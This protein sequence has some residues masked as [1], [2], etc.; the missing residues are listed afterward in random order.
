M[1]IAEGAVTLLLLLRTKLSA[2]NLVCSSQCEGKESAS[3]NRDKARSAMVAQLVK[4]HPEG[5][6]PGRFVAIRTA[7]PHWYNDRQ[8]S[9]RARLAVAFSNDSNRLICEV[10]GRVGR[11]RRCANGNVLQRMEACD[12][13]VNE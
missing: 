11:E 9:L 4:L 1:L 3:L 10:Q 13:Q 12:M 6:A 7:Y 8:F 5:I 2:L